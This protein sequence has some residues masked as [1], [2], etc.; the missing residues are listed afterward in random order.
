MV[1]REILV[2]KT[3]S[4]EEM[5]KVENAVSERLNEQIGNFTNYG[6]NQLSLLENAIAS[7]IGNYYF[8]AV[9]EDASEWMD[10]FKKPVK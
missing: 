5:E 9:G 8:Y 3:S 6:T 4:D 10:V 7:K 1:V 2:V